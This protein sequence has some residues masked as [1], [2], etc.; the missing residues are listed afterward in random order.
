MKK[1]VS[2]LPAGTSNASLANLF[3][4]FGAITSA[5]IM[6][7]GN[8]GRRRSFGA[9]ENMRQGGERAISKLNGQITDVL[10]LRVNG[11]RTKL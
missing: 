1:C 5:R 4:P 3:Q 8:S 9:I 7:S 2:N 11:A 10:L 6:A